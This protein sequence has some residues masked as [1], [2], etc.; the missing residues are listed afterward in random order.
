MNIEVL[1]IINHHHHE[2]ALTF[3]GVTKFHFIFQKT[4]NNN[5]NNN[6]NNKNNKNDKFVYRDIW[7]ISARFTISRL[8]P[9]QTITRSNLSEESLPQSCRFQRQ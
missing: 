5:D 1:I 9:G 8:Y 4:R 7:P 2:I 6:V 3:F